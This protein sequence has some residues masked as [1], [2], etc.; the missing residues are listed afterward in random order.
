M[1]TVFKSAGCTCF[2]CRVLP[3]NHH[4]LRTT[5][6]MAKKK[7]TGAE[8]AARAKAN[9]YQRG[10]HRDKES[11]RD[12]NKHVDKVKRDHDAALDRYVL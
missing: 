10:A 1:G 11:L 6:A 7:I 4:L 8:L 5:T 12:R 2:T 3:L 9:G